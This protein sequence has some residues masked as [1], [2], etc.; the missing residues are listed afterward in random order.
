LLNFILHLLL[1]LALEKKHYRTTPKIL[2]SN[3]TKNKV[4][5]L[6]RFDCVLECRPKLLWQFLQALH[7]H[8]PAKLQQP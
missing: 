8:V 3:I 6:Q 2:S 4:R 7:L 1:Q 5:T